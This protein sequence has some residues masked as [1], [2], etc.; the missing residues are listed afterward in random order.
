MK[1]TGIAKKGGR[2]SDY[3]K[4]FFVDLTV[5]YNVMISIKILPRRAILYLIGLQNGPD[6]ARNGPE[7]ARNGSN[8]GKNGEKIDK[9]KIL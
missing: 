4:I 7:R 2:G 9:V 5:C 8:R 6:R 3:T 1:K